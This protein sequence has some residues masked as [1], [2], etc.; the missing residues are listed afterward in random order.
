MRLLPFTQGGVLTINSLVAEKPFPEHPT[1]LPASNYV[2]TKGIVTICSHCRR[3]K[4]LANQGWDWA[5]AYWAYLPSQLSH[6]L[7]S[8]CSAYYYGFARSSR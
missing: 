6:G 7:C 1:E 8:V 4:N 5:P 3:V 2:S